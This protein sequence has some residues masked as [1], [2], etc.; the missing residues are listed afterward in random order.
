MIST[1]ILI[2]LC[3]LVVGVIAMIM[4]VKGMFKG[5]AMVAEAMFA[6]TGDAVRSSATTAADS[7]RL[8]VTMSRTSASVASSK[9]G[10]GGFLAKHLGLG[11][12]LAAAG[13]TTVSGFVI[14]VYGVIQYFAR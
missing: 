11:V 9:V 5:G 8:G 2:A 4:I 14:T 13:L 6:A 1:G 7:S 10:L 12:L 3:G